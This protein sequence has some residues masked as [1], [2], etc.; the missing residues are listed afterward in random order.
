MGANPDHRE[1][2]G[3]GKKPRT[4]AISIGANGEA[5][6][7]PSDRPDRFVVNGTLPTRDT[8]GVHSL[9]VVPVYARGPCQETF[10]G[11]YN[12][13]DVF[14]KIANC[15]GLGHPTNKTSGLRARSENGEY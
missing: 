15:L 1:Q 9:T 8:Q 6:V 12:N 2:Y 13:I 5:F 11:T 3:V 7:N 4:P 14:F 10:G